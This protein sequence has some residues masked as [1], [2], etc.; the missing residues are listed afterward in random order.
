VERAPTRLGND[1]R[2]LDYDKL[3][4]K[5]RYRVEM[6]TIV[7]VDLESC[8]RG[9]ERIHAVLRGVETSGALG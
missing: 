9:N 7:T 2:E 4:V 1:E 8:R 3:L 6:E 5:A